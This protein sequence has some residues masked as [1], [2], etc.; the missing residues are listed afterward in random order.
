MI[1]QH[2]LI[3]RSR[4]ALPF[5]LSNYVFTSSQLTRIIIQFKNVLFPNGYPNPPPPEPSPEEQILLREQLESRLSTALPGMTKVV[6]YFQSYML[7]FRNSNVLRFGWRNATENDP[8]YH[9][10]TVLARMQHPSVGISSWRH[11]LNHF[12]RVGHPL[13]QNTWLYGR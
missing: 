1:H 11:C 3:S 4:R 5:L 6:H 7:S 13:G 2:K 9:R 10:S 8:W 12:P